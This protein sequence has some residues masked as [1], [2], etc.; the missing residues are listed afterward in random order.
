MAII[1]WSAGAL[2]WMGPL[3]PTGTGR[4]GIARLVGVWEVELVVVVV[5]GA[6]AMAALDADADVDSCRAP[7]QA[8]RAR[9]ATKSIKSVHR[10]SSAY[11]GP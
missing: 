7:S 10:M 3:D 2:G 6:I 5:A 4:G 1:C 9:E 8:T 11:H